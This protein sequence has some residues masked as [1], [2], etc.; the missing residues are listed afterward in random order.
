MTEQ[1]THH[2]LLNNGLSVGRCMRLTDKDILCKLARTK[3]SSQLALS[4]L[5]PG[6][7]PPLFHCFDEY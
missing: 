7:V 3:D 2:N 5:Y 6:N 4:Y 1:L